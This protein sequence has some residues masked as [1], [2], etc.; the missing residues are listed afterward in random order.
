MMGTP[1]EDAVVNAMSLLNK[2]LTTAKKSARRGTVKKSP[3]KAQ[4]STTARRR[5]A[6]TTKSAMNKA[7][8]TGDLSDFF[9]SY[10]NDIV[11]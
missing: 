9:D 2:K 3:Q 5:G 8:K 6:S 11:G 10:T 4:A 1:M 7:K